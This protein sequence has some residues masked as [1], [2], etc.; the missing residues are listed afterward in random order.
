MGSSGES[1]NNGI[2]GTVGTLVWVRRRNG[3]WWPGRI[4]GLDELTEEFVV[5]PRSGTPVK[6]L[7]RD[8]ASVDWYNLEKSKRVKAF[9]CGEYEECITKAKA[10]AANPN[11][12]A[13][14]Y[15]R[16]EDAIIHALEIENERL[17]KDNVNISSQMSNSGGDH[18]CSATSHS[19][20]ENGDMSYDGRR[21]RTPN[22][23]EDDGTEGV[24][25]MRGLQDLGMGVVSKR[26]V[27]TEGRHE[28]A[29][30]L[31]INTESGM[32]NGSL[33]NGSKSPSSL[34]RKRSVVAT[35]NELLRR[36][37][38]SK[39]LTKVLEST[40]MVCIPV[41]GDLLPKSSA[42]SLQLSDGKVPEIEQ[43]ES[44]RGLSTD[45][46]RV[47]CEIDA[48]TDAPEQATVSSSINTMKE[49]EIPSKSELLENGSSKKIYDVRPA[50]EEKRSL[51]KS[52]VL[53]PCSSGRPEIGAVGRQSTR[54]SQAEA[55]SL[56]NE[57][58]NDT[59]PTSSAVV[60]DIGQSI[61]KGSSK[62]QSK[63]KRNSRKTSRDRK[64]N[65]RKY[66]NIDDLS[67]TSLAGIRRSDVLCH[68]SDLKRN[69]NGINGSATFNH[70]L[71]GRSKQVAELS[72]GP[73]QRS[74]PYRQSRSLVPARYQTS[75][76]ISHS[77]CSDAALY[78]VKLEVKTKYRTQHVPLVSLTS[79]L[80][81]KAIVGHPLIV[82]ALD[83]GYSD[84]LF[85]NMECDL[86]GGE[87]AERNV[88]IRK[89]PTKHLGSPKSSPKSKK[90]GLLQKKTRKLS[91]LT[92]H[93]HSGERN[94][95]IKKSSGTVIACIP[96]KVVFS[97]LNEAV[98]GLAR[99]THHVLKTK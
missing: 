34:R 8:D 57:K 44:K 29:S 65:S 18:D 24:K 54:T 88:E 98:S 76:S 35:A 31:D 87:A 42:S 89:I 14:K 72:A 10:A 22:D 40:E 45:H 3:S 55:V 13:V 37:S 62:W 71:Q 58:L 26:S 30:I 85:D 51:G 33:S 39:P 52:A 79:K 60:H 56:R 64:H 49:N 27:Q 96:L 47:S 12:K 59:A 78:D 86:E 70:T 46:T 4:V 81:G 74:L 50:G 95:P 15:A 17:G 25:R 66:M 7:G 73:P 94:L 19:G 80:N 92:G 2:D 97:R 75:D 53:A 69:C 90:S 67:N 28:N 11:K 5:S 9:R 48:Y 93:R 91:S 20:E 43:N 83:D 63:G 82:K 41:A 23:S 32:P 68:V 61:E 77:T 36:K 99:P 1:G 6:L 38:R 21:R 16:R 84:I